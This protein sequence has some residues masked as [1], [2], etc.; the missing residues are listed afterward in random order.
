MA[1]LRSRLRQWLILLSH[2]D[3]IVLVKCL[4][5]WIVRLQRSTQMRCADSDIS[6]LRSLDG[7]TC[8][9]DSSFSRGRVMLPQPR[10]SPKWM[11]VHG[12]KEDGHVCFATDQTVVTASLSQSIKICSRDSG[13]ELQLAQ[14]ALCANCGMSSQNWPIQKAP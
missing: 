6:I 7:P 13:E 10:T 4:R 12:P 11:S 9:S 5:P 3:F 14:R 1:M 2:R 8:D